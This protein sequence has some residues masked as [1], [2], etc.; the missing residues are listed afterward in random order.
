VPER[1]VGK[2]GKEVGMVNTSDLGGHGGCA[3]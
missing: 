1:L 3:M 2:G